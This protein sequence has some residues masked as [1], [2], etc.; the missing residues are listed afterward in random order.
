MRRPALVAAGVVATLFGIVF[1]LQGLGILGGSPMSGS[2][3]WAFI[4]PII[5]LCG[6][7]VIVFALRGG[8][9]N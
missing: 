6:I 9:R 4:G 8:R 2:T 1:T 3:I 7:V 5:A